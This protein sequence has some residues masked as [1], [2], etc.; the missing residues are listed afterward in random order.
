MTRLTVERVFSDPP[1]SGPTPGTFTILGRGEWVAYL[2]NPPDSR[3]RLDLY[4]YHV[5][6]HQTRRLVD[7]ST[8]EQDSQALTDEEKAQRERRR[9]FTNGVSSFC[10]SP[11]GRQIAF[12]CGG[13][14]HLLDVER[15]RTRRLSA[16][17]LRQTDLKFSPLGNH[18]SYVRDGDLYRFDLASAAEHRLT[19]GATDTLTNGLAEFIAQEEMHRFDGHWWAPDEQCIAFT[20]V[21]SSPIPVAHRYEFSAG[22][23]TVREQRYPYTGT[24]NARVELRIVELAGGALRTLNW[25]DS[26]QDYLARVTVSPMSVLVQ[27]QS[28]DQRRLTLKRLSIDGTTTRVELTESASTWI[29]LHDNLRLLPDTE[30]FVWTSERSGNSRLYLYRDE[31]PLE[32]TTQGRVAR[33]VQVRAAEAYF[34]GWDK[35]PTE[36]HLFRVGFHA[37]HAVHKLTHKPGW[38]DAAV[39]PGGRWYVDRHASTTTPPAIACVTLASE[40]IDWIARNDVDTDHPYFRYVE[41]H[42]TP[43]FGELAASDGQRLCYRLTPPPG[44]DHTRRYPAV[45]HVYGGP[46]VQRVVNDWPP[47]SLQLL[48]RAGYV[49]FELDNR[50]SGN[51]EPRFEAP[52]HGRLGRAEVEDQLLGLSFLEAQPWIDASRIAVFGHSYGGYMTL[53]CMAAAGNR[54]RAGVSVA[55]VTDWTLYDTH[56]TERYLGTPQDNP[57]GYASSAA[58]PHLGGIKGRLLL[59]HGMADDNVLFDNSTLLMRELQRL[60]MPFEL[61]LYPGAKHSLQERDVAIHRFDTILEFLDRSMA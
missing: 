18:L 32:L 21:D 60:R 16:P 28:R 59:M 12:L 54:L 31:G 19:H 29:N 35:D 57:H 7:A 48:A 42:A 25:A 52:I 22:A 27:V 50:G 40:R 53:M 13:A 55:P 9:Q 56:Y 11:D 34:L 44:F 20:R 43:R 38:H 15:G 3:E 1:L 8:L 24:A 17:G 23:L 37:P 33:V 36:Q 41:E 47:W 49:V 6:T 30:Q 39:E 5:T 58:L 51:R 10:G 61:M 26:P 2:A 14:V 45:I 4:G 46:G